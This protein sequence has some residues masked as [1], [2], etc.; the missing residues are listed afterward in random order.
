MSDAVIIVDRRRHIVD[1]NTRAEELIGFNVED[2]V[3]KPLAAVLPLALPAGEKL[4]GGEHTAVEATL[5]E[6]D[7]RR[8]FD[9]R[10]SPVHPDRGP[11]SG[12]LLVLRD[13]TER[14][15][16]E[17]RL[18]ESE[19][20]YRSLF[21][22]N[23]DAAFAADT[24]GRVTSANAAAVR[25][26]GYSEDEMIGHRFLM[27]VIPEDRWRTWSHFRRATRG[28]AQL[29]EATAMHR[30]GHRVI[31]Q[32]VN[33]PIVVGGAVTGV[34]GIARDVTEQRRALEEI[35]KLEEQNRLLIENATDAIIVYDTDGRFLRVNRTFCDMMGYTKEDVAGRY[36]LDVVHV[37][38]RAAMR[39]R[40]H[41]RLA[42]GQ[43]PAPREFRVVTRNGDILWMDYRASAVQTEDGGVAVQI[44][45]R[46]VTER[47]RVEAMLQHQALHDALT[48]LPNRT[49]FINRLEH[50]LAAAGRRGGVAV[51]FV[52]LD[53][54]KLVNDSLGHQAG[55]DLLINVGRRLADVLAAG[56]T[57]ARFGGDEFAVLLEGVDDPGQA[58]EVAERL[59]DRVARPADIA[60]R[61]A[62]IAASIGIACSAGREV[63]AEELLREADT[64]MYQAKAQGKG[65]TVIFDQVMYARASER[66]ELETDLRQALE[67]DELVLYYQPTVDLLT[68]RIVGMEALA[69]WR[70]PRL[71]L[72][73]PVQF[74]PIAEETG[75]ILPIG[76]WVLAEAFRQARAWATAL[77]SDCP[78]IMNVNLS[79]RQFTRPDLVDQIAHL[80]ADSGLDPGQVCLEI[81]ESAAME[82]VESAIMVCHQ[83]KAL[84]VCLAIDDF[85]TGYSSLSQLRRFPID[86]IKIDRS[87]VMELTSNAGMNAIV[88]AVTTLAAE[89][90]MDTLVE[91]IETVEQVA[92][93]IAH[94]CRRAQ[95]FYFAPPLPAEEMERLLRQ[96]PGCRFAA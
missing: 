49:L 76:Q 59:L 24:R 80:L 73:N 41:Q 72:V 32:V 81:T 43:P 19:Q 6:G 92:S 13:V 58:E 46:D 95:G 66:L 1:L 86:V 36:V 15:R 34:Y 94:G 33:L 38:D 37:Q 84:G 89:L 96:E 27:L 16:A 17:H 52:D 14:R 10:G 30:D 87:F 67:R 35:R 44:I 57:L 64:A 42:G 20:R 31:L 39:E 77:P 47:R 9:L 88:R 18:E 23:L 48:G 83:L 62:I 8:Y 40:M 51:L 74:I 90:G 55:D 65:R 71:G 60:G 70:H 79:T 69:R 78:R 68:A 54:F 91:G 22:H 21:D 26:F 85:G 29:Y 75:L 93:V 2:V 11:A 5:G 28:E 3:A 56:D 63:Q 50:A 53:G 82:D 61:T 12:M 25:T 45:A 4:I 7:A